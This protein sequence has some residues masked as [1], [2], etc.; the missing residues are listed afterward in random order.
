MEL[1]LERSIRSHTDRSS[2]Q[3]D[4]RKHQNM[5]SDRK[6]KNKYSY[7]P[8]PP[9]QCCCSKY[10][11]NHRNERNPYQHCSGGRGGGFIRI[12]ENRMKV[13]LSCMFVPT[14]L[15]TIVGPSWRRS[16][17]RSLSI[18]I[19]HYIHLGTYDHTTRNMPISLI[20]VVLNVL[21]GHR[22]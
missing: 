4:C 8:T 16:F 20:L 7:S 21:I 19:H 15:S 2:S 18:L 13:L 22:Y 6:K 11:N 10:R 9:V 14:Y 1:N 12:C 5:N 3:T 17:S